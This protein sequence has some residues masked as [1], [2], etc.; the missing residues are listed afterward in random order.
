MRHKQ[1]LVKTKALTHISTIIIV[2]ISQVLLEESMV[3]VKKDSANVKPKQEKTEATS[4]KIKSQVV[5]LC[6]AN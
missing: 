2:G 5:P 3:E 4:N 1:A 6:R